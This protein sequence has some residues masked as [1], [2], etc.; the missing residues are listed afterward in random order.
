M[1]KRKRRLHS[2]KYAKKY[3]SVRETYNRLRGIVEESAAD[4]IITKEEQQEIEAAKQEVV[5]AITAQVSPE[6]ESAQLVLAEEAA[7]N[8]A[9]A[10][11]KKEEPEETPKRAALS[12]KPRFKKPVPAT[13]PS[14]KKTRSTKKPVKKK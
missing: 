3:A 9:E 12:K 10:V 5:D 4:G 11:E 8:I 1:G 13:T 2:P 6:Q 14:T 7:E